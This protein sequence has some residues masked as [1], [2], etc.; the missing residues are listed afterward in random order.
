MTQDEQ[1]KPDPAALRSLEEV[2]EKAKKKVRG[3]KE[4][5]LCRYLPV[6]KGGYMHHF[7]M[8]KMKNIAPRELEK[9]IKK[10][11]LDA[12]NPLRVPPKPR[13][14]RG[15][16]KRPDLISLT[17]DE[18]DRLVGHLRVAGDAELAGKLCQKRSLAACKKQLIASIRANTVRPEFWAAYVEACKGQMQ[19]GEGETNPLNTPGIATLQ[20]Q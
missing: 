6:E 9:M 18:L 16:R 3:A 17:R 15:S 5:D 7:T 12:D 2:I 10:F 13:A 20:T 8:R 4:N 1:K 19:E 11:I 14:A